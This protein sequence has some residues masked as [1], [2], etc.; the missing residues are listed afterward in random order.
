MRQSL[1]TLL[2]TISFG[3]GIS[4]TEPG[5][6][7]LSISLDRASVAS[8]DSVGVALTLVNQAPWPKMVMP[9]EF[10]GGECSARGFRVVNSVNQDVIPPFPD[11]SLFAAMLIQVDPIELAP[12]TSISMHVFWRPSGSTIDGQPLPAGTY[13]IIGSVW[14]DKKEVVSAPAQIAVL[15]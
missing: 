12:G 9:A 15:Q 2:V 10:Y 5:A 3:A 1:R 11:C 14:G 8:R 6:L 7:R 13:R 4:C